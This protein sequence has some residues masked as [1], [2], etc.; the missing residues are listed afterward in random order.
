[1]FTFGGIVTKP[2]TETI[3][4]YRADCDTSGYQESKNLN[5]TD[6]NFKPR[7][8]Q[9]GRSLNIQEPKTGTYVNTKRNKI[10]AKGIFSNSVK[11]NETVSDE[12]FKYLEGHARIQSTSSLLTVDESKNRMPDI[13]KARGHYWEVVRVTYEIS[14]GLFTAVVRILDQQQIKKDGIFD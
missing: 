14:S 5:Q 3:I 8:M 6:E 10:F 13:V 1:M 4:I 9:Y 2:F 12:S 7:Q 11:E